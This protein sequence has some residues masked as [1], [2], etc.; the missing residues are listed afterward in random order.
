MDLNLERII[1]FC[2]VA[3]ELSFTRASQRLQ[4]DQPWLSRQVQQLEGQL[5]FALFERTTRRIALTPEGEIFL[6]AAR[7]LAGIA[8]QTRSVA[9]SLSQERRQTLRLGVSR[10]TFWVSARGQLIDTFRT[11]YP[12]TSVDAV[13]GLSPRILLAL[14]RRKID[15]GIIAISDGVEGF[16]YLPIHRS[17]PR[18]MAPREHPLATKP[19]IRMADLEGIELLTP[20]RNGNPL[21]YDLEYRPFEEAGVKLRPL[22]DGRSAIY[23]FATMERL[24]MLG[25]EGEHHSSATFVS[26][27]VVDCTALIETAA[28]R[29]ANDDRE[30]VR[31]FWAAAKIIADQRVIEKAAA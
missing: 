17:R 4:V 1:R 26:R 28:V 9:K 16:D 11:R 10:A 30:V 25:R 3:E 19:Q 15:A 2:V 14:Q 6:G 13:G 22:T 5:G 18:L 7:E 31:K 27:D 23:H 12:S 20:M 8:E 21:A 29:N 24:F